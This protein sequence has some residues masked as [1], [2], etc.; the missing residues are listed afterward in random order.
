MA[1]S[2]IITIDGINAPKHAAIAPL[3]PFILYP[4]YKAVL[5]A[6]TPGSD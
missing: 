4:T 5:A 6:K 3:S 2:K 1:I